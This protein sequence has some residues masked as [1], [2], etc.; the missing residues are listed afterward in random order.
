MTEAK[1]KTKAT[2]RT[3]EPKRAMTALQRRRL[4]VPRV[5][6]HEQAA[7]RLRTMIVRG[8]L[9]PGQSLGEADLSDALGISRTPL[10]E[11]LKQLASEGLVELRLNHSAVV[12]PF[13][14]AEL[15]ELFEAVSGIERCAAELAAL[16]ME[17]EDFERLAALQDKIEWHHGRG[18]L[19]DYFQ[20]N[21][22]IH[23]AIVGFARNAVLKATH[24]ALLARA[25]RARFFALSVLGRWDESVRE[26]QEIL[27]ALK[28]RDA[29]RAGQ[30]LA[31]HV[32][33]TG[34]IVAETLDA[35]TLDAEADD[36]AAPE[37]PARPRGRKTRN[38][39][40]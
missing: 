29:A 21:Q 38:V 27:A 39:A 14:R 13:R 28:R 37:A 7:A 25:E 33:R 16:R 30:I 9:A 35:K 15:A 19:R 3:K 4:R 11:A 17:P 24:E 2:R 36:A 18:E 8:E 34:E 31:H 6:L 40:P 32:R 1:T 5:G 22:Q 26:H 20:V 12:A 10:R 23:S